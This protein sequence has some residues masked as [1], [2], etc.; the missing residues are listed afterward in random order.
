M[1]EMLL[2]DR[3]TLDIVITLLTLWAVF[4]I[5]MSGDE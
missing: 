5:K 2:I 1:N 4:S 3:I